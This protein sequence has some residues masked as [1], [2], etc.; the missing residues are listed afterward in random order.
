M[1]AELLDR[2]C[3]GTGDDALD[4]DEPYVTFESN[5]A[6]RTLA[7]T[8]FHDYEYPQ[9]FE[10]D[11]VSGSTRVGRGGHDTELRLRLSSVADRS[12]VYLGGGRPTLVYPPVIHTPVGAT[13]I[14]GPS[15]TQPIACFDT[16]RSTPRPPTDR[17]ACFTDDLGDIIVRYKVPFDAIDLFA[18]QQDLI[19]IHIDGNRNGRLDTTIE[20]FGAVPVPTAIE[21]V[22]YTRAPIAKAVNYIA[23]GDS[24]SAGENGRRGAAGFVGEYQEDVGAA[25]EECKRWDRAYPVVFKDDLLALRVSVGLRVAGTGWGHYVTRM[26]RASKLRGLVKPWALRRRTCRRLLVPSIL[27]LEGRPAQCQLRISSDQAMNVST[28]SWYSGSSPVS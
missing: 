16:T 1:P 9:H 26:P 5:F 7:G 11:L 21:P 15:H 12:F 2:V 8:G 13:I 27:P 25:D 3:G 10:V 6:S 22:A 14:S 4:A 17:S 28:V 18:V 24:Y 20:H 19:R 23:L